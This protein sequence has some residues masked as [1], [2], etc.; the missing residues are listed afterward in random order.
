MAITPER[1][2]PGGSHSAYLETKDAIYH[3]ISCLEGLVP[4]ITSRRERQEIFELISRLERI[5][6]E[7]VLAEELEDEFWGEEGE[8]P[9]PAS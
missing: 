7:M 1:P 3:L 2:S 4:R 8:E 6:I 5:L 9:E